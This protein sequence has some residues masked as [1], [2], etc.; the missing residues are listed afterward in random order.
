MKPLWDTYQRSQ[1]AHLRLFKSTS[2]S[3][4]DAHVLLKDLS[5]KPANFG[6]WRPSV[7]DYEESRSQPQSHQ[8]PLEERFDNAAPPLQQQQA[9][10]QQ[11]P[12]GSDVPH[13][14]PTSRQIPA[15]RLIRIRGNER[16][17]RPFTVS[18]SIS[19]QGKILVVDR[20]S[21]LFILKA[22]YAQAAGAQGIVIINSDETT[23]TMSNS[24]G[25]QPSPSDEGSTSGTADPVQIG[26]GIQEDAIDIHVVMV[27]HSEGQLLL[28]WIYEDETLSPLSSVGEDDVRSDPGDGAMQLSAWFI[29]RKVTKE[30]LASAR[31]SYN[32]LPIVNIF[33]IAVPMATYG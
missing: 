31:L 27:G 19:I 10:S 14:Q 4:P 7:L 24:V 26:E 23:F 2:P 18:Q 22:Y 5:I 1:D 9:N 15:R 17:C 30:E 25:P 20:G 32:N 16:G 8:A 21:C 13:S 12:M 29:Q 3:L 28:D 11:Q 6:Y 33:P